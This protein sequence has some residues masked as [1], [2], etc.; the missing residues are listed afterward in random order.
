MRFAET[1]SKTFKSKKTGKSYKVVMQ[2]RI[3]TKERKMCED[4]DYWLVPVPEGTSAEDERQIV[5]HS[6]QLYGI[7]I[8]EVKPSLVPLLATTVMGTTAST[9]RQT[10]ATFTMPVT[11]RVTYVMTRSH[12]ASSHSPAMTTAPFIPK[13]PTALTSSPALP[14]R[15]TPTLDTAP[16]A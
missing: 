12:A 7:L 15:S 4:N 1:Y 6:I 8:K 11:K 3:N 13:C 2:N 10:A 16:A 9:T 5:E 14:T